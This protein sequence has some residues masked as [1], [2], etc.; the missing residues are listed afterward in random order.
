MVQMMNK[1]LG[2]IF[3]AADRRVNETNHMLARLY[4]SIL[5]KT[6]ITVQEWDRLINRYY[7]SPYS[8][9]RKNARDISS[10]K[11][12]FNRAIA[13]DKIS[14][15]NFFKAICIMGP[16]WI[17]IDVTMR[18]SNGEESTHTVETKN[19]IGL[20]DEQ[21]EPAEESPA[22][23]HVLTAAEQAELRRKIELK[24]K[25]KGTPGGDV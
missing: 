12:N 7:R 15:N 6:Q 25:E 8:K 18:F 14:W 19:P 21:D 5:A 1:K 16:V 20:Y 13:A 10:D 2:R 9:V 17:R 11:N 23:V 4:R 24:Q 22:E 3:D